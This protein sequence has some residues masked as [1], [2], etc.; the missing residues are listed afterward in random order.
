MPNSPCLV[1]WVEMVG[2]DVFFPNHIAPFGYDRMVVLLYPWVFERSRRRVQYCII[3]SG[4]LDRH[5]VLPRPQVLLLTFTRRG[6]CEAHTRIF[7][8]AWVGCHPSGIEVL[9]GAG[10]LLVKFRVVPY[11]DGVRTG[12]LVERGSVY[13]S[14]R[15]RLERLNKVR[16]YGGELFDDRGRVRQLYM[17]VGAG[18]TYVHNTHFNRCAHSFWWIGTTLGELT[19]AACFCTTIIACPVR[20]N[21]ISAPLDA[22]DSAAAGTLSNRAPPQLLNCLRDLTQ[23]HQD[24]PLHYYVP[25][26]ISKI[27]G[28]AWSFTCCIAEDFYSWVDNS[29]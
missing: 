16:R 15:Q 28:S 6:V 8:I 26:G 24:R 14:R 4:L 10:C 21:A 25:A 3:G 19:L 9:D 12:D 13:L 1:I 23:S 20:D 29:H 11:W 2:C 18:V 27:C 17:V 22:T 5:I 7:A